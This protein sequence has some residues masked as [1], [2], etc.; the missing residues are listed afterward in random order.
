[1]SLYCACNINE[2]Y[3]Q[4]NQ[5][6]TYDVEDNKDIQG[7]LKEIKSQKKSR[8]E[9][10]NLKQN[11]YNLIRYLSF[12]DNSNLVYFGKQKGSN[13]VNESSKRTSFIGVSK[14]GPHWQTLISI[15]KKKTYI[16]TFLTE[17]EAGEA[18][19]FYSMVL[20]C[21]KAGTNFSY[22]KEQSLDLVS[23]FSYLIDRS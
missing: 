12:V 15:N 18:Y 6:T 23:K 4:L 8:I 19:D 20:N 17:R 22:T 13:R 7:L 10:I 5:N 21:E 11:F 1:M 2:Y 14:N 9:T 3:Y 16:G